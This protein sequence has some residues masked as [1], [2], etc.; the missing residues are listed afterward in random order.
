M[1]RDN[2]A[3]KASEGYYRGLERSLRISEEERRR[4]LEGCS[5]EKYHKRLENQYRLELSRPEE[6]PDN[7]KSYKVEPSST[8]SPPWLGDY[9][10][11]TLVWGPVLLGMIFLIGTCAYESGK[12]I[13][14]SFK[15]EK[16]QKS[17]S[18]LEEL[19]REGKIYEININKDVRR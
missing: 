13:Y 6:Y 8:S 16:I 4:H 17:E 12:H 19:S 18:R 9:V 5:E 2:L 1:R 7:P 14:K 15:E 10:L 11:A 3:S